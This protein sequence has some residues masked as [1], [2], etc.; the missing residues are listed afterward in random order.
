MKTFY[1]YNLIT[2]VCWNLL[3][4]LLTLHRRFLLT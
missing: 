3:D 1:Y 4:E 2:L